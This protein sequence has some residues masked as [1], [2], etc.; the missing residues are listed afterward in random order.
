MECEIPGPKHVPYQR[1]SNF[2]VLMMTDFTPGGG[3]VL[4]IFVRRGCAV[5]Q[6][7]VSLI[8]SRTYWEGKEGKFS[9]AGC[10]NMPKEEILLQRVI[11]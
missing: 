2:W 1:F 5:F 7:I 3:G 8:F 9:G 6:G 4:S 11:I 10:Q